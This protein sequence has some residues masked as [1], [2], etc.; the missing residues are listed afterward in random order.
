MAKVSY[1]DLVSELEEPYYAGLQMGDRFSYSRVRRKNTLLSVKSKKGISQ[2]S[3]L[4][5][6]GVAWA[7]LSSADKEA[8]A[9]A[10]AESNMT[11]WRLFVQDYCARKANGLSGL[12]TPSLLHQCWVGQLHIEAPASEV[13]LVQY[14]PHFYYIYKKLAGKKSMYSPVL[15]DE[16]FSLPLTVG[17]N[18]KSNLTSQGAGS[19]AKFYAQ[20]WYSYQGVNSYRD[21]EIDLDLV[22]DWKTAEATLSSIDTILIAY[23]LY[24]HLYNLRGDLYIDN[25][26]AEHDAVNYARDPFCKDINQGFTRNYYQIP[27]HWSAITA[28]EGAIFESVYKDF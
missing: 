23:N 20:I 14:H 25:I 27:K 1:I 8:W 7:G 5:E 6:I 17:L 3:L 18:Y 28:P 4:P 10:A 12:A 13:K 9:A 2:R 11:G 15:I 22:A 21:L 16:D 26:R 19:F 24:I